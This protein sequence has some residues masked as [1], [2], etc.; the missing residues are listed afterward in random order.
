MHITDGSGNGDCCKV[1]NRMPFVFF[2]NGST[3]LHI[4]MDAVG[5][6]ESLD[7][8]SYYETQVCQDTKPLPLDEWAT[9][10]VKASG[11]GMS[12]GQFDPDSSKG[13]M[14]MMV[15]GVKVCEVIGTEYHT[16]PSRDRAHMFLGSMQRPYVQMEDV[17]MPANVEIRGAKYGKPA[18]NL[19]VGIVNSIQGILSMLL[20]YPIGWLGD[21]FNRYTLLR[22]NVIVAA[23]AGSVMIGAVYYSNTNL[24]FCGIIL[25]TWYQQ[26]ISSIIY[27]V[28]AD[29]VVRERRTNAGVNYKTFSALAMSLG[30][31]IQ[32]IVILVGPSQ[33]NWSSSTFNILLLPGWLLL[34]FIG[35]SISGMVPVGKGLSLLPNTD[36]ANL[37][38]PI[39]G[40]T[41]RILSQAWL[42]EPVV[43]SQKR[44]FV[45]ALAVNVFFIGTLLANGMTVRYFSLYF[46]Q[47]LKFSPAQL[48]LLN[49]I[50]RL[51][52]AA[53]AQLGKPLAVLLGRTNLA[54]VLH[55]GSAL[56]TLGIYGG[57]LGAPGPLV[58]CACYLMRFACLHARDPVL[59]SITMD[60]VPPSQRSR[61]AALNSLRSLSF[62]ASAVLGG[63]L[64]DHYGYQ[65]SF[66]VTVISLL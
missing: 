12:K 34:P 9:V 62:S 15:N 24:L 20:M 37:S 56:F 19:F 28:L 3:K 30:P 16:L 29:N 66:S 25:F 5:Q 4:S 33:D 65:F 7:R 31:A 44:G 61:W 58:A 45:V 42:D 26:F 10:K 43:G 22:L 18:S 6:N 13:G 36:E 11:L 50:C 32:L 52:I 40:R 46:T 49:A 54:I 63:Y 21:F 48:C 59:Y 41:V 2:P 27:A 53:F 51:F 8:R 57:P 55:I 47:V 1:G 35:L 14:I 17:H 39:G 23:L 38:K 64:A 60:C